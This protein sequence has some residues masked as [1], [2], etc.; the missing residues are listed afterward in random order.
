MA[1]HYLEKIVQVPVNVPRL[2]QDDV[3][4]FLAITLLSPPLLD[5]ANL[6]KIISNARARRAAGQR[7]LLDDH[8]VSLSG[9]AAD[10]MAMAQ[11]LA[12]VIA[13]PFEGNPQPN[14]ALPERLL[15]PSRHG[16]GPRCRP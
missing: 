8:G 3:R 11:R 16:S 2:G 9:E 10:R 6:D 12:P 1:R 7:P 14:Q 4:M 5:A 15:D 13:T